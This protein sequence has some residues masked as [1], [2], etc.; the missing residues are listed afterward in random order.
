M[1]I[2]HTRSCSSWRASG[3]F[4]ANAPA[5]ADA[6][7]VRTLECPRCHARAISV[8]FMPR[9]MSK[10]NRVLL[11]IA[12]MAAGSMVVGG[13][14]YSFTTADSTAV[15]AALTDLR[16][17]Q[18]E[19][20]DFSATTESQEAALDDYVLSAN[21]AALTQFEESSVQAAQIAERILS[22]KDMAEVR[23][24]FAVLLA[25]TTAWRLEVAA[26]AIIAVQANDTAAV[27]RFIALSATDHHA[28]DSAFER[29]ESELAATSADFDERAAAVASTTMIAIVIAFIF[30][31]LAFGVALVAVRRF[32]QALELDAEHA[33]V[34]NRFTE[35][36]SFANDDHDVAV[37][38]LAAL[39]RL[40]K[41]DAAVTHIL[42]RSRDRAVPE[43]KLGDAIAEI[44]PLHALSRCAG[45]LRGAMYVT[46]DLADD[47]SVRC[48]I[49]P[50]LSGTLA[51]VPL[52]SG[53]PVGAVHLYWARPNAL[54]LAVRSSI[55]R[56]TE[57]AALSIGN[58][59]LLTALHGQANTDPRTGLSNSR[60]FDLALEEALAVRPS[61]EV[62]S[63]LMIDVD[64]FKDFNDRYG[65]PA[66]DE[67]LRALGGV[68]RS[69]LRDHDVAARYGGD[70]FAV[71][72]RGPE[73]DMAIAVTIAERIRARAEA[74][75]IPLGP[76]ISD[77]IT[78]S[79]GIANAP[80]DGVDR[81]DVLRAA[82]QALYRA[83][84]GGRN[85][86][87]GH[88]A[89]TSSPAPRALSSLKQPA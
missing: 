34:L 53:E 81:V 16:S 31:L 7:C 73:H 48:P 66:G 58:R 27:A 56:I 40:V 38:N 59:R 80:E 79:I 1:R 46:D 84:E 47:L 54:S 18:L 65:H 6:R 67:A 49:Y 62:V 44:L 85:R 61:H 78:L 23:A 11:L 20:A 77:R 12:L 35:M 45:V 76:D 86:V 72:L 39:G 43:A 8:A 19:A 36:T 32:G 57:H 9:V 22:V 28:I 25:T 3:A 2:P 60:A 5:A 15:Q 89:R 21:P 26:P 33:S 88:V 13:V 75:M 17:L 52:A 42:N 87:H 68:L 63:V 37:A 14:V 41:P 29:L 30:V 71:F 51:C 83:K 82:D 50:A 70:E 24:V 74:T 4:A 10:N 55:A 69:C 64:N